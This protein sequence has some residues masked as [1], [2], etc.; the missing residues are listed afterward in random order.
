MNETFF[1]ALTLPT[2]LVQDLLHQN[3][4]WEGRALPVIPPYRRWPFAKLLARLN[5]P[6]ASI[7]VIGGPRQIGKTTLQLQLVQA[8]VAQGV[9]PRRILRAQFDDLPSLRAIKSEEPI[10]RIVEWFEQV[11]LKDTLNGAARADQPAFLFFDE[12]QNLAAWEVQ[13]KSLVDHST[14]RVMVTGSSALRMP[15]GRDSLAGRIQS[16]EVGPLRLTEIAALRDFGELH[17]AQENNGW[18][19][20]LDP[21]F[22]REVRA[23]GTRQA[24]VL[25]EAFRAFSARGAYPLSQTRPD[26]AWP[27]IA[28]QLN[29]TV[30]RR[31][32]E[33]DL[34]IDERGRKR[35]QQLLEEV[36]RMACR[37]VGQSPSPA[38]LAREA[39]AT[40][41]ANVGPQRVR[42][43]VEFLD[44]SLLI[45][46]IQPLEIRLKK[47]RGYPKLC[48][49][50][51]ALRAAWLQEVVPLDPQTLD[52]NPHLFELAGRVAESIAGY[53][54]ASLTG[55]DVAHLPERPDTPEVDFILTIGEHR[56]PVEIKYRRVVDPLRDT[57]GLRDFIEKRHNHASFGLLIT[58]EEDAAVADPRIIALPLKSFLIVR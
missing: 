34:R 16:F 54:L 2:E 14:V 45:R 44:S 48:L 25:D 55:L 21:G 28:D 1:P 8:L 7:L 4:W 37:Y 3:P 53:Y 58:R 12:V 51:H 5:Q 35:D 52:A 11:I 9:E 13:L 40:L 36:F 56:I 22:W 49:C 39:Q 47:R 10:L 50:D 18:S 46:A 15:M 32:I 26:V 38:V 19:E 31:V 24:K 20:W 30:I 17:P 43:Y 23:S 6:L 27:E 41:S 57:V 42:H 29:E 33:H